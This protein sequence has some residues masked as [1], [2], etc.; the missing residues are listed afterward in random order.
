MFVLQLKGMAM[1]TVFAPT[2]ANFT[3]TY[4]EI[5]VYFIIIN[6]YNLVVCKFFEENWFQFS[7][8]CEILLKT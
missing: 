2:Y 7:D 8:D 1:D 4:H 6:T 5:H 3:M